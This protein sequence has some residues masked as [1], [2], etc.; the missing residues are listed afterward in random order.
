MNSLIDTANLVKSFD[1]ILILKSGQ[2][3][4]SDMSMNGIEEDADDCSPEACSPPEDTLSIH[5][6]NGSSI[7]TIEELSGVV[8]D[9][10]HY[11][12]DDNDNDGDHLSK[13]SISSNN[14]PSQDAPP[15]DTMINV[16]GI[17]IRPFDKEKSRRVIFPAIHADLAGGDTDHN[18][19]TSPNSSLFRSQSTDAVHNGKDVEKVNVNWVSVPTSPGTISNKV[20]MMSIDLNKMMIP[21]FQKCKTKS[22]AASTASNNT[23]HP[24]ILSSINESVPI[25]STFTNSTTNT[26]K[27]KFLLIPP[28][29]PPHTNQTLP[30]PIPTSQSTNKKLNSS[31]LRS[32]KYSKYSVHL[33][34]KSSLL[35]M[36]KGENT[37]TD[38]DQDT[39]RACTTIS[40]KRNRSASC[41][42]DVLSTMNQ[43]LNNKFPFPSKSN[44][45][46]H[47]SIQVIDSTT[48][49][50]FDPRVWVHEFHR[51]KDENIWFTAAELDRFKYDTMQRIQR[52][53]RCNKN[54]VDF[55]PSGT[56]RII[57]SSSG[58]RASG[59][60]SAMRALFSNP[61]L[62][63]EIEDEDDSHIKEG[64]DSVTSCILT[65]E[66]IDKACER[67]FQS[68][69]LVDSHDIFLN[70]LTKGI[71]NILPHVK[72]S[73]AYTSEEAWKQ[74]I[75]ARNK[76][77][78][79][80]G[81]CSHGFDLI[82]V[83]ERIS[84]F[85]HL[86]FRDGLKGE[87]SDT[88]KGK[89]VSLGSGS[90][91]IKRIKEEEALM[92]SSSTSW[93]KGYSSSLEVWKR[94]FFN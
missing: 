85:Q 41:A 30:K 17:S 83:E 92:R 77:P 75:I 15:M 55:I 18:S 71:K 81:G 57:S 84:F 44:L 88:G 35:S 58:L 27:H 28:S 42:V 8:S 87:M 86:R 25:P 40:P 69:L 73:S 19:D 32:G 68:V 82:I 56:G 1:G 13:K 21:P 52:W 2:R 37:T 46:R 94:N 10:E 38:K 65:P 59:N 29:F 45:L 39:L 63:Y 53:N 50:R 36:S 47:T 3:T 70:L 26:T 93:R 5:H 43:S 91:L 23:D 33:S 16:S 54:G 79:S 4:P 66:D 34:K 11:L 64:L 48:K 80:E 76:C 49:V 7:Q 9:S 14:H 51:P 62:S 12:D 78:M 72:V 89:G 67:E 31:I 24:I 74:I 22:D 20:N 6:H 90:S 60:M 61:A